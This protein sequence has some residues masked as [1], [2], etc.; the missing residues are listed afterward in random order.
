MENA[1][2]RKRV[3]EEDSRSD[4]PSKCDK[5]SID[6]EKGFSGISIFRCC[7]NKDEKLTHVELFNLHTGAVSATFD[8]E[9]DNHDITIIT[10]I[11]ASKAA[12]LCGYEGYPHESFLFDIHSSMKQCSFLT[13]S[14]QGCFNS[15]GTQ[16]ICNSGDSDGVVVWDTSSGTQ[17]LVIPID[18]ND[19][20]NCVCVSFDDKYVLIG[21]YTGSVKVVDYQKG[22]QLRNLPCK[23][24]VDSLAVPRCQCPS[25]TSTDRHLC[26]VGCETEAVVWDFVVATVICVIPWNGGDSYPH[27]VF[28][29]TENHV[30][31]FG[32]DAD[33]K[34]FV[35]DI[36]AQRKVSEYVWMEGQ[37]DDESDHFDND[38]FFNPNNNTIVCFPVADP[39]PTMLVVD[40]DTCEVL[41]YL[42]IGGSK[43][44]SPVVTGL[45]LSCVNIHGIF[46][47]NAHPG[48]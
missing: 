1:A 47:C 29:N 7:E 13:S 14:R 30:A 3:H 42:T 40:P 48:C 20:A 11:Y 5:K 39:P 31:C 38:A 16:F 37:G 35:W 8:L 27:F 18:I 45:V 22:T 19:N 44:S 2:H 43:G 46:C 28:T 36:D 32:G 15:T 17:E 23:G 34:L 24:S 4:R 41:T 33:T 21:M 9:Y 26:V 25:N 10:D 12:V 6:R